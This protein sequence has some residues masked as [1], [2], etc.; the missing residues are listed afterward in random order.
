MKK[1]SM[2]TTDVVVACIGQIKRRKTVCKGIF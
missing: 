2:H 1:R